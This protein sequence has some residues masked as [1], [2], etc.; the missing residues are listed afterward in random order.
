M[1]FTSFSETPVLLRGLSHGFRVAGEFA[2]V[3]PTLTLGCSIVPIIFLSPVLP[4]VTLSEETLIKGTTALV[5]T[6]HLYL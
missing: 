5:L 2:Q 3:N 6:C 1:S 4:A